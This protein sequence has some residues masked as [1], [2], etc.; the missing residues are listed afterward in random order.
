MVRQQELAGTLRSAKFLDSRLLERQSA[1]V[2]RAAGSQPSEP[3]VSQ[4]STL[5]AKARSLPWSAT[6][7][8]GVAMTVRSVDAVQWTPLWIGGSLDRGPAVTP[9]TVSGGSR[10]L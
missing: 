7:A 6:C 10:R 9:R 1:L 5:R 3:M 2:W 4:C 8:I